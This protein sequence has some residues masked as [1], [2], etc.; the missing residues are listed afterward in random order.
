MLGILQ[1]VPKVKNTNL[2][3]LEFFQ[4]NRPGCTPQLQMILLKVD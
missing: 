3:T 4:Q 1:R 2:A